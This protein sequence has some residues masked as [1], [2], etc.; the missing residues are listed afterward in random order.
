M[1]NFKKISDGLSNTYLQMEML[2]VP[3]LDSTNNDRRGRVWIFGAGSY[4]LSTR[5]APNS[6]S[7][8]VTVCTPLNNH[9]APCI[10]KQGDFTP[11]VLASRSRHP[12]GVVRRQMR[13]LDRFRQQRHR[14]QRLAFAKHDR[15]FRSAAHRD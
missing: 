1:I 3:S 8:D 12:G 6:A 7:A 4:Q 15:R 13:C 10:R 9:I 14:P 5:M 11:F 2:Q